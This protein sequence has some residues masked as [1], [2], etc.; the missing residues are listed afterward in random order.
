MTHKD[1]NILRNWKSMQM[2]NET[3]IP[4][5]LRYIENS[6]QFS[7]E[8][9]IIDAYYCMNT[10]YRQEPTMKPN[11]DNTEKQQ[12]L[13]QAG[14]LNATPEKILDPMFTVAGDFFDAQDLL[15]VRYEMIRVV[16]IEHVTLAEAA[17]RFG[18]S[19]PTC[20][21]M[22]KAFDR[23]GLQGLIPAPRG[24]RGP[25]KITPQMLDFVVEYKSRHGRVGARRLVPLIEQRFGITVHPRGLEKALARGKKKLGDKP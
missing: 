14:T 1:H 18:V 17:K 11:H 6:C 25:H 7:L 23:G 19:R 2:N 8:M 16:R 3:T 21:R 9:N 12:R 15:Q 20:F 13:Q 24:P 5:Y 22:T 10:I 4:L